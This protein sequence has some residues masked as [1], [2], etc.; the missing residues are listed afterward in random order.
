MVFIKMQMELV[1]FCLGNKKTVVTV[2]IQFV[3]EESGFVL[4]STC[5]LDRRALLHRM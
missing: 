2:N 3:K 1:L 5:E 4:V